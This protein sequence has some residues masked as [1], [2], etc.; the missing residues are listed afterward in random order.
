MFNISRNL[1]E[2][3]VFGGKPYQLF[4]SFDN[5]LRVFD[6]WQDPKIQIQYKPMFALRLLTRS[7]EFDEAGF[8]TQLMLY[9]EI[10]DNY[11][12]TTKDDDAGARYDLEGNLLPSKPKGKKKGQKI[13]FNIGYDS[14]YIYAGFMQAYGID[15][16]DAQGDLHWRKFNALL[17]GLPSHTKFAEILKLRAWEPSGESAKEK[18]IM[19]ERQDEVALPAHLQRYDDE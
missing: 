6:M 11:I 16:I 19:K 13:L 12:S 9:E 14:E 15:L 8:E 18:R 3:L 1:D 2:Q 5:V 10:F 7:N 4:L 17:A